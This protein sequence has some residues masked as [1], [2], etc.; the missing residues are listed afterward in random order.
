MK[1]HFRRA[2]MAALG[3]LFLTASVSATAFEPITYRGNLVVEKA[4]IGIVVGLDES[5][6][7][8]P[9]DDFLDRVWVLQMDQ[10]TKEYVYFNGPGAVEVSNDALVIYFAETED[11]MVLRLPMI[12]EPVVSEFWREPARFEGNGLI[13][14]TPPS[15]QITLLAA[16]DHY[17]FFATSTE[18]SLPWRSNKVL[19]DD[20]GD[21]CLGADDPDPNCTGEDGGAGSGGSSNGCSRQCSATC[22]DGSSCSVSCAAY[23]VA[24]CSSHCS[25]MGVSLSCRCFECH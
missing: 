25:D 14:L 12:N 5:N 1:H 24:V 3:L 16:A 21:G 19:H 18:A 7:V 17:G 23:Q 10:P 22:Q 4:E 2:T 15:R 20:T 11:T 6:S 8:R 13:S 9:T